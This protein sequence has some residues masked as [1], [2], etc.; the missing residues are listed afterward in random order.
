ML[1]PIPSP[2]LP[3]SARQMEIGAPPLRCSA[4]QMEIG[5]RRPLP[6]SAATRL[7]GGGDE[8][9]E[10]FFLLRQ[11]KGKILDYFTFYLNIFTT[12]KL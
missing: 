3:C 11:G 5:V 1:T 7:G 9:R 8:R 4:R 2:P 10:V 12:L 6:C